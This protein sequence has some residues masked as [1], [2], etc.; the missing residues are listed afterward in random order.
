M[1]IMRCCKILQAILQN[2]NYSRSRV[3]LQALE[4]GLRKRLRFCN[5]TFSGTHPLDLSL[6]SHAH[7]RSTATQSSS[8]SSWHTGW[9]SAIVNN[10]LRWMTALGLMKTSGSWDAACW[11]YDVR[12]FI[13]ILIQTAVMTDSNPAFQFISPPSRHL[14]FMPSS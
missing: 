6:L 2:W 8:S 11:T 1:N 12:G 13:T 4:W 5:I 10:R 7:N 9:S 3:R 14:I